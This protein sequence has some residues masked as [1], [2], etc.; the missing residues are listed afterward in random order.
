MMS[1][2]ATTEGL[3]PEIKTNVRCRG[4]KVTER[5]LST[6][7][8]SEAPVNRRRTPSGTQ[9]GASRTK[10]MWRRPMGEGASLKEGRMSGAMEAEPEGP[11]RSRMVKV[12]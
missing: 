6:K 8:A 12:E 2:G 7:P 3:E 9:H 11:A 1:E 4:A 5:S 10:T